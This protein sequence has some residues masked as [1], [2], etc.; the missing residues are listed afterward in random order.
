MLKPIKNNNEYEAALER[1]Y[2]LIQVDLV[3]ESKESD[4]LKVLS[5]LIKE[6][7]NE[8]FPIPKPHPIEAIKFRLDQ[9]GI[10]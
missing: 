8:H 2:D 3:S 1:A 4:E 5:I 7:E 10:S 6:Y 9:M